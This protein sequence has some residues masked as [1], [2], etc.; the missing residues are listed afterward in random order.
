MKGFSIP[1][2]IFDIC[3]IL[4]SEMIKLIRRFRIAEAKHDGPPT[5][6]GAQNEDARA[7]RRDAATNGSFVQ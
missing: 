1:M 3:L 2:R 4:S 5:G 6:R 7:E